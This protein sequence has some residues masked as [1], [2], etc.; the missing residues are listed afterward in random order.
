VV[1]RAK[2][3]LEKAGYDISDTVKLEKVVDALRPRFDIF[4]DIADKASYFYTDII[5]EDKAKA[6]LEEGK[7]HLAALLPLL[8]N[9]EWSW[10]ALEPLIKGY[11][12]NT[13]AKLGAVMQPIRAALTGKL[14]SP[15]MG[16]LLE[17]LGKELCLVRI[18]NAI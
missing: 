18:K 1:S 8:E 11:A 15:G 5:F 4:A 3:Y 17:A 14:E 2:P 6:K 7:T 16:E 9:A 13:G 10:N 12:E